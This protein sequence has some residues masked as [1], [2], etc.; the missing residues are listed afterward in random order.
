ML[1]RGKKS[2]ENDQFLTL[3]LD[4]RVRVGVSKKNLFPFTLILSRQGRGDFTI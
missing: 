1:E 4:G 2:W 3:P